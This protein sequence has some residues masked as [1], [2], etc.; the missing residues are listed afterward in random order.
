MPKRVP[1]SN[2]S[3][4]GVTSHEAESLALQHCGIPRR[5]NGSSAPSAPSTPPP[6]RPKIRSHDEWS[7]SSRKGQAWDNAVNI[8]ESDIHFSDD[9]RELIQNALDKVHTGSW[10]TQK[11]LQVYDTGDPTPEDAVMNYVASFGSSGNSMRAHPVSAALSWE[12]RSQDKD[13]IQRDQVQTK[14]WAGGHENEAFLLQRDHPEAHQAML[15]IGR[16]HAKIVQDKLRAEFGDTITL[17]R[18]TNIEGKRTRR[19]IES[20]SHSE[21]STIHGSALIRSRVP[22][23]NIVGVR[24]FED[25]AIVIARPI[26]HLRTGR[27]L[28]VDV[29]EN[30]KEDGLLKRVANRFKKGT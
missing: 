7:K 26:S 12:M 4:C 28:S 15:L 3:T 29:L 18:R 1:C 2:P 21:P 13:R 8:K 6:L 11:H 27:T 24:A 25:E 9:E 14:E 17:Y 23:E 22:I 30:G 10:R 20:W 16:T 5:V 19:A